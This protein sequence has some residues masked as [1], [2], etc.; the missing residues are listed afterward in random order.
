M[1][2]VDTTTPAFIGPVV[3]GLVAYRH[4]RGLCDNRSSED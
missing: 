2:F 4:S 1:R 3:P